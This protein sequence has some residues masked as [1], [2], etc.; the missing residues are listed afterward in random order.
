MGDKTIYFFI[1]FWDFEEL[2]VR[3]RI[4]FSSILKGRQDDIYIGSYREV[5]ELFNSADSELIYEAIF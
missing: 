5:L 2:V 4:F 1:F 3:G